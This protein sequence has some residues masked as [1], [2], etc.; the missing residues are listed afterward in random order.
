MLCRLIS[1]TI[2]LL[3]IHALVIHTLGNEVNFL[4]IFL[5]EVLWLTLLFL[6]RRYKNEAR[7]GLLVLFALYSGYFLP[8]TLELMPDRFV[9]GILSV[10]VIFDNWM[11]LLIDKSVM[12]TVKTNR[13]FIVYNDQ[14]IA[15]YLIGCSSLRAIPMLVSVASLIPVS[16]ERRI[17]AMI[18]PSLLVFPTNALRVVA[19]V[20]FSKYFGV[21][22][23]IAHIL[24]SPFITIVL[25]S[26]LMEIQ[27]KILRGMLFNYLTVGF[28]TL[29]QCVFQR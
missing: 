8:R 1:L 11:F 21:N 17:L 24:L 12:L 15:E 14:P 28:E 9:S 13:V 3:T 5:L 10:D 7:R 4:E 19:I 18:I 16:W 22:M 26:I 29:L 27:D 25:F 23:Q 2:L 20:L 6:E